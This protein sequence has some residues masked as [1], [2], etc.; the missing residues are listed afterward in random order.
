MTAA[1][2]A[3]WTEHTLR[4]RDSQ[5]VSTNLQLLPSSPILILFCSI[6]DIW[7]LI[8]LSPRKNDGSVVP[9]YRQCPSKG[10][11]LRCRGRKR[12]HLGT[13]YIVEI[14]EAIS[15]LRPKFL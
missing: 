12:I 15:F 1:K 3:L 14:V 10:C 8:I 5:L 9:G 13:R 4:T 7:I 6:P 2:A 11:G